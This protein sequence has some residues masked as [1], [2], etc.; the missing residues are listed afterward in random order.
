M[1]HFKSHPALRHEVNVNGTRRLLDFAVAHGVKQVVVVSSSYVYGALPENPYYM[2]ESFPLNA[3]RTYPE[4]RDLAEMDMLATR[5]SVALPG[6]HDH[7]AAAGERARLTTSAAPS[8][9][10]CSATTCRR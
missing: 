8:A 6:H 4:M 5:L 2:D 7:R 9:A 3:S 10:T 1:R